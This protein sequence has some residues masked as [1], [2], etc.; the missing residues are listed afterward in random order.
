MPRA[1]QAE[2]QP[3]FDNRF[4]LGEYSYDRG[5][6]NPE[7]STSTNSIRSGDTAAFDPETGYRIVAWRQTDSDIQ[8]TVFGDSNSATY[9]LVTPAGVPLSSPA[10]PSIACAPL[11][12]T[13]ANCVI[14]WAHDMDSEGVNE[15]QIRFADFWVDDSGPQPT[16]VVE[17]VEFIPWT[18]AHAAPHVTVFEREPGDFWLMLV[19]IDCFGEYTQPRSADIR[20]SI[21][22]MMDGAE[23]LPAGLLETQMPAYVTV[24][25]GELWELEAPSGESRSARPKLLEY[26]WGIGP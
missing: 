9:P 8:L 7:V 19:W 11:S 22:D 1:Y 13:I 26:V 23:W 25:S 12:D 4:V 18:R 20:T 2:T 17:R 16:I 3:S 5:A 15:P 10:T 21:R 24:T 6:T 14:V